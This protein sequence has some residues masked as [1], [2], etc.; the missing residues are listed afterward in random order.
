MGREELSLSQPKVLAI[1]KRTAELCGTQA[2]LHAAGL[3]LV[4]ATN[5][6]TARTVIRA[7]RVKG[8]ILCKYSWSDQERETFAHEVAN[9]DHRMSV[10]NCSGCSG[11]DE[12]AHTPG[13]LTDGLPVQQLLSAMERAAKA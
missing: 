5:M 13:I 8:V 3:G 11:C 1:T 6:A 2:L 4:T 7:I 10:A 9:L 12:T